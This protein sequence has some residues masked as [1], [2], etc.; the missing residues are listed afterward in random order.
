MKLRLIFHLWFAAALACLPLPPHLHAQSNSVY[1][2]RVSQQIRPLRIPY[3]PALAD[4]TRH[5]ETRAFQRTKGTLA[6]FYSYQPLFAKTV[7][8][9]GLPD[10]FQYIP[11]VISN[12]NIRYQQ[13]GRCGFWGLSYLDGA[14]FGLRMDSLYDERYDPQLCSEAAAAMLQRL[15]QSFEGDVWETFLAYISSPAAVRA[16]KIRLKRD[17]PSPYAI[18]ELL[19][20]S[21]EDALNDLLSWIYLCHSG[22]FSI[23]NNPAATLSSC[24]WECQNPIYASQLRQY[25]AIDEHTYLR[26]N[27][28][29]LAEDIP[30]HTLLSLPLNKAE[31]W[32][33]LADS[34]Y[35]LYAE[36]QRADSIAKSLA[37][38]L[39]RAQDSVKTAKEAALQKA[40]KT[41]YTVKNGDVLGRIASRYGVSVADIKR[42]NG[43]KSDLIQIGQKL[44]IY[45]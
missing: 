39:Q 14:R 26:C 37:D 40:G 10:I 30:A 41:V 22:R 36:Q 23:E 29:L 5:K 20:L 1:H 38:S 32:Q 13:D 34:L 31:A 27:P 8:Q 2:Q 42:W 44:V 35:R 4:L 9:R 11:L 16:A 18:Q 12:M 21:G 33:Q 3:S 15:Y 45:R 25:L 24:Q 6:V 7:A 19:P 28:S 43:L 17:M